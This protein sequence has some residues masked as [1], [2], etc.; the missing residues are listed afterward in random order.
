MRT[1]PENI[2]LNPGPTGTSEELEILQGNSETWKT[3]SHLHEDSTRDDEEAENDFWT[4]TRDFIYRHHVVPRVKLYVPREESF[5]IPMKYIDVTKTTYTSLDV[6][7]EKK[8]DDCWNV[9]GERELPDAWTGFSRFFLPKKRPPDGYTW[10][11]ERLTRKQ[12]LLVLMMCGQIGGNFMSDAAKK[13]AQQGWTIEK[14]KF[15]NA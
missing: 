14:P 13:K 4:I 5:P 11:R 3:P 8:I 6:M 9:E 12:K 1:A 10:S 15:D 2:H 7:L